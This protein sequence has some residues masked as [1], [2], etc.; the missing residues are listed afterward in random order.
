MQQPD[1]LPEQEEFAMKHV[2]HGCALLVVI[3]L[4]LAPLMGQAGAD[5]L[6]CQSLSFNVK[7]VSIGFHK[8]A[9]IAD[10]SGTG[11]QLDPMPLLQTTIAVDGDGSSC[12]IAHFSAEA[13]PED[14]LIM[15]QV[16]VDGVPM[17]GHA[18]VPSQLPLPENTQPHVF[19]PSALD[20]PV[21]WD[22]AYLTFRTV[23]PTSRPELPR[24]V[25]YN[26]FTQ[27]EPGDHIVE[28][29]WAGCCTAFQT[30]DTTVR[31][32][33]LTLHYR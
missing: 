31:Y 23:P 21:V 16:S 20:T 4:L 17:T 33:V 15:F 29:R 25:S 13:V 7:A 14:N 6:E 8:G 9:E 22:P 24:M 12:L 10:F 32:E 18:T 2:T 26:F 19:P 28:V 11:G 30:T 27:V 1:E 5:Q 3:A